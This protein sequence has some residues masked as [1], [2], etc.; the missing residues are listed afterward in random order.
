MVILMRKFLR[1]ILAVCLALPLLTGCVNVRT[2]IAYTIYPLGYL[3]QRLGGDQ[4]DSVSIQQDSA[5]IVQKAKIS[6]SYEEILSD[7]AV[8]FHI[9]ELE[10]Y[11]EVHS[12][13]ISKT[14]A[15][16]VDLSVMN[17]VYDFR[18]YTPVTAGDE[19]AFV[20]SDYYKGEPFSNIDLT[21]KDLNIWIDPIAMLSTA[22]NIRD[23]LI[24]RY[25]EQK[26]IFTKNYSALENDLVNMDAQYQKLSTSMFKNGNRIAFVS[27]TPSFG[28]W[29]KTYGIEVYPIVLSRYGV[30]P[31]EKQLEIIKN[32]IVSDGVKYI[33]YE[34]NMGSEMI[35]LFNEL[36]EELG[37]IRV[38]LSNLSSLSASE[39][40]AGKDYL[41][42]MYENLSVLQTMEE[43]RAAA[44][45]V[46]E[47]AAA[48]ET[49]EEE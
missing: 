43:K 8:L 1:Y 41:S 44:A 20:E 49:G 22:G 33:V 32:R 12:S 11:M 21:V 24:E 28:N 27:M 18:R 2:K 14:G 6:D 19:V 48:E 36:Q 10:P 38:D 15:E 9:G 23:W 5:T 40:R 34:P 29:Q 16:L 31:N 7:A 35:A 4:I 13:V 3:L 45:Q 39:V 46:T 47:E 25:P 17:A 42:I 30:L 37:L 26:D